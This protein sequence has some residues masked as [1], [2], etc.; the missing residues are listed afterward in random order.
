MGRKGAVLRTRRGPTRAAKHWGVAKRQRS[1][2]RGAASGED[3]ADTLP[4][5]K[6]SG[7]AARTPL[8]AEARESGEPYP[9]SRGR[10]REQVLE[11]QLSESEVNAGNLNEANPPYPQRERDSERKRRDSGEPYLLLLRQER[12]QRSA[13]SR[14]TKTL[15][16]VDTSQIRG[17][18]CDL[19][20]S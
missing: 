7:S 1:V 10:Q 20:H 19:F 12:G 2:N 11:V 13:T 5:N 15:R 18:P 9:C 8:E 3:R 17:T 6:S 16:F 4:A 14:L